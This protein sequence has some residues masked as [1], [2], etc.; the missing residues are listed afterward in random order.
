M[1]EALQQ[2]LDV[3]SLEKIDTNLYRGCTPETKNKRV[4]GGQVFA[5]AMRA[6]QDTVDND[7]MIHDQHAYFPRPVNPTPTILT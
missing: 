7:R 6:A 4:F 2:L 5:Q 1:T 3:L